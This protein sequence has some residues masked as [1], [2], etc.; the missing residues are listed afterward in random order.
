MHQYRVTL[1]TLSELYEYEV[2]ADSEEAAKSQALESAEADGFKSG[3]RQVWY[4]VTRLD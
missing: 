1:E 4:T 3:Y 2:D